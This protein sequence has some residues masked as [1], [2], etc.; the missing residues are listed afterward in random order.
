MLKRAKVDSD[1][2]VAENAVE[3]LRK[4]REREWPRGRADIIFD[5]EPNYK[6]RPLGGFLKQRP[7]SDEL[8]HESQNAIR[9][10]GTNI[11]PALFAR[12]VYQDEKYDLPDDEVSVGAVRG[13]L[14]LGDG[15]VSALPKLERLV[16]G[17]DRRL[18][19]YALMASCTMGT[20][21]VP[22]ITGALTNRHAD[23]RSQAVG[24]FSEGPLKS[25]PEARKNA[26]LQISVLLTDPDEF[27]RTNATNA[28]KELDLGAA[29][30]GDTK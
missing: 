22:L 25:F 10:M 4:Y 2:K 28:L 19:L 21:S 9:E 11:I 7:D 16:N 29:T 1:I 6:G 8:P 5:G 15:A 14:V 3:A 23:V 24:L 30:R 13:F 18:A 17:E 27:V 12:L 26:A 20:N